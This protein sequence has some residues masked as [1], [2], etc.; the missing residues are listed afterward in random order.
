MKNNLTTDDLNK[1][2]MGVSTYNQDAQSA[3]D[4]ILLARLNGFQGISV[5]SWDSHKNNVD[6]SNEN[7]RNFLTTDIN[8]NLMIYFF[9]LD[10]RIIFNSAPLG[11]PVS[12]HFFPG[13]IYSR[14]LD[15]LES[16]P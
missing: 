14:V 15:D 2:I 7:L 12:G 1:V 16:P 9:H 8:K 13:R 5:F 11:I 6:W 10:A 4:K 3:A